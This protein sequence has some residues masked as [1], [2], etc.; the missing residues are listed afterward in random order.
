MKPMFTCFWLFF[1]TTAF[2]QQF[3]LR[4][5]PPS[6]GIDSN[7]FVYTMDNGEF[8]T[9]RPTW[10]NGTPVFSGSTRDKRRAI[11]AVRVKR[12]DGTINSK[13]LD[14][15]IEP[16]DVLIDAK[17]GFHNAEYSGSEIQ[18]DFADYLRSFMQS[19]QQ[20]E[21]NANETTA[22]KKNG[23]HAAMEKLYEE[24][25]RLKQQR[26][27]SQL[28]WF[29][30]NPQSPV[31]ALMLENFVTTVWL[32]TAEAKEIYDAFSA[33]LRKLPDVER[34]GKDLA[35]AAQV[36]VGQY[37]PE[38]SLPDT[39]GNPRSVASFKGKYLFIDL[40]ASWCKPCRE[41]SPAIVAVYNQNKKYPFEI[42]HISLDDDKK[43][44]MKAIEMDGYT[45]ANV[46]DT[47]GFGANGIITN[48]FAIYS[49]PRNFL[50]DPAGK[51]IAVNLRGVGLERVLRS[52]FE[53]R[54]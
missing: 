18:S 5:I 23:D 16:G 37:F 45:W 34:F 1:A 3:S 4:I 47:T 7:V 38:L 33:D 32:N 11:L 29:R 44:W 15:I 21:R 40:W 14:I 39:N 13:R 51:I 12:E 43:K 10:V 54:P 41:E 52:I 24:A 36:A 25:E 27:T 19:N 17:N 6:S 53:N 8:T 28:A 2:S 20:L 49:I 31:T 30:A 46:I 42:L 48:R 9:L 35:K 22:A 50:L 26:S